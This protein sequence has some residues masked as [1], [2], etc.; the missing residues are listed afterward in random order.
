[1][2]VIYDGEC[3]FCSSYVNLMALRNQ[4]SEIELVNARSD[5]PRVVDVQK[6]GYDLNEGMI[7]IYNAQ[8]YYGSEALALISKLN[9]KTDTIPRLLAKT[10]GNSTRAR[11]LYPALKIGRAITLKVLG[12]SAIRPS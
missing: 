8:I 10:L 6:K 9:T 12:R 2:I 3:P 7:V 5:D 11:I 4:V 1:M